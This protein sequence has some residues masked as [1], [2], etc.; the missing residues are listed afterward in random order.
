[1][2]SKQQTS[3]G[4]V[5]R[6]WWA[7][8]Q[9]ADQND[10]AHRGRDAAAVA[11]LRRASTPVDAVEEPAVLDLY[12]RLG[13]RRQDIDRWLSRVAVVAAVLAHIRSDASAGDGGYRRR[14]AEMLGGEPSLMSPLRFKRL[15]AAA[16]DQDL[17]TVFRRA[18][19]L[20]GSKNI[21]VEDVAASLLDWSDRRRMRWAFDYYGAGIAA[22]K[23]AET[24]PVGNEE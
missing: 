11:H 9:G 5:A 19:A 6:R 2:T 24:A 15:L 22:P 3:W 20:A 10:G 13:F 23:A 14:F 8:L 17:L 4:H 7:E 12:K 18:V 16:T 1:M 21:N